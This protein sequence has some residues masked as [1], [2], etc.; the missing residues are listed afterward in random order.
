MS[1]P[2]PASPHADHAP[3]DEPPP[4]EAAEE[5]DRPQD[6]WSARRDLRSHAPTSM[7]VGHRASF[8][9][10]MVG[11]D[12]QGVGGDARDVFFGGTTEI[13]YTVPGSP[14]RAAG[15]VPAAAV[16]GLA[17][18]FAAPEPAFRD[19]V[20][21]LRTE[22]VLVLTGPAHSGRR[23]AALMLL[24]RLGAAPLRV[25]APDTPQDE[26]AARCAAKADGDGDTPR[27][28]L[29]CD[30]AP[31]AGADR[32]LGEAPLLA[33]REALAAH[34]AYLVVTADAAPRLGDVAVA[35]WAPPPPR[36][37]L[38][39]HLGAAGADA[40]AVA[41]LLAHP[42]AAGL[43]TGARQPRELAAF[44]GLLARYAAGEADEEE[45]R[46]FPARAAQEQVAEWL[47]ADEEEL[48]L[49]EKAF[50]VALAAFDGAPYALTAE[51]GD[52]LHALLQRTQ[53]PALPPRVPVFGTHPARRL[54]L[55]RAHQRPRMADTEWGP[56]NQLT[57][58][59]HDEDTAPV[60]LREVWTSHPSARPA[61]VRW[62][63]ELA[64][65]ARPLVRT[66][67]AA[68]AAV[69]ALHDLPSAMALV[70]GR[71]ADSRRYRHRTVAATALTLAHRIGAPNVLRVLDDWCGGAPENPA[72]A[73][74]RCWSA[75]RALC[76]LG[77]EHPGPALTALR[78]AARAHPR[79][80]G[81]DGAPGALATALA[82]AVA[83]LLLSPACAQ[84]AAELAAD[85]RDPDP[86]VRA[87]ALGGFLLA[88]EHPQDEG[89]TPPVLHRYARSAAVRAPVTALWR[90]ALDDP[91]HRRRA[92][93]ALR[94]WV[95]A[96]DGSRDTE[97]ALA[98]LL[99][100]L[101]TTAEERRRLD[102]LLGSVPGAG[103]GAPPAAAARLRTVLAAPR[104]RPA[105][106]QPAGETREAREARK[107]GEGDEEPCRNSTPAPPGPGPSPR[108]SG[109]RG[110]TGAAS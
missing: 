59:F 80:D 34:H 8:D 98:A 38:A 70:I 87:A 94:R 57:A 67:A 10:S 95:Y 18:S 58:A 44:A 96:A 39:A 71:L 6:A 14:A 52:L 51:L 19:L 16:A 47:G 97:W 107:T 101:V 78:G 60:L 61:L 24:R 31:G 53:D 28:L 68:T 64:D 4:D 46:L 35:R 89:P 65:D 84:V 100:S 66:R 54:R 76:L 73:E 48:P 42:T 27:G 13:H 49:R 99:P 56:V 37:V 108:P 2:A 92:L 91:A 105:P 102:H 11:G 45:L 23:T 50:L 29:L 77:P 12:F 83:L 85:L 1:T 36:D 30:P 110:P 72:A 25:L 82:E 104:R 43:L 40:A 86:A 21:R 75:I 81:A 9:G 103:G 41:R 17:A 15:E 93:D 26:L 106:Q 63:L 33:A 32:A 3:P 22:R 69:F 109:T 88:C 7:R 90:A 55:A 74:A 62:L 20:E 79:P 5:P